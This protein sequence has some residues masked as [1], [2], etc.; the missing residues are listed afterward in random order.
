MARTVVII[1]ARMG[2]TRLPGKVLLDLAG[3]TVLSHV[4]ARAR[5]IE[6]VDDV[7]FAIPQEATSDPVADEAARLGALVS[8]GPEL[9][10]LERYN[11]AAKQ[12]KADTVMRVTSDCPVIDPAVCGQVLELFN[13]GACDFATNNA[14]PSWPH[15]LDC[16]VFS[17]GLLQK[18]AAEAL[19]PHEREHVTPWMRNANPQVTVTNVPCPQG[20][21]YNHRWTLDMPEDYQFLRQLF[22]R[23]PD[24]A[25]SFD[26][27]VPLAIVEADPALCAINSLS[28][29]T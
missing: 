22:E 4:Y 26:Y 25:N 3:N 12:S 5:A 29:C 24:G 10:V 18:A 8:R 15:G 6:G 7:C 20:N 13:K 9:D 28:S 23:I 27:R 2:S 17:A 1:Q 11:L 14:P 16:E 21:L 19:Q